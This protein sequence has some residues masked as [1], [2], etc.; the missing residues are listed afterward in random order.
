M[1]IFVH[2]RTITPIIPLGK[3]IAL[4]RVECCSKNVRTYFQFPILTFPLSPCLLHSLPHCIILIILI[5]YILYYPQ[6]TYILP[7][8]SS[9]FSFT[10]DSLSH[11]SLFLLLSHSDFC[12]VKGGMAWAMCIIG[13]RYYDIKTTTRNQRLQYHNISRELLQQSSLM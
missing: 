13:L 12:T 11:F 6:H 5:P 4:S 10:L 3:K 1:I 9:L 2:P 8:I 7:F